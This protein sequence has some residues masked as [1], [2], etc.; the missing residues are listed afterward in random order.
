M[1]LEWTHLKC[2]PYCPETTECEN[3]PMTADRV[4]MARAAYIEYC[5]L[6]GTPIEDFA[7]DVLLLAADE[8]GEGVFKSL[9][10][11]AQKE[12]GLAIRNARRTRRTARRAR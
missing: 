5:E 4:A 6:D 11:K 8:L 10:E 12:W 9:P 7:I 1:S 2:G 3:F